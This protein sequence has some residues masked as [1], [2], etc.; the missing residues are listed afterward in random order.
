MAAHTAAVGQHQELVRA[1][2]EASTTVADARRKENEAHEQLTA[3]T[4][5]FTSPLEYLTSTGG[6][7]AAATVASAVG[8]LHG[9]AVMFRDKANAHTQTAS[10]LKEIA[11]NP[12]NT[13][14]KR[15]QARVDALRHTARGNVA[16]T[17]AASNSSK[18]GHLNETRRG[19]QV[20]DKLTRYPGDKALA[21]SNGV[22]AKNA[23][24]VLKKVPYVGGALSAASATTAIAGGADASNTILST[25]TNYA[26]GAAAT[27]GAIALIGSG[28]WAVLG[29]VAV[30]TVA[31]AG[32]GWVVE[33]TGVG[34]FFR[35]VF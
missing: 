21:S 17:R 22:L 20:F 8:S 7:T 24:R 35:D 18:L 32:V 25:A 11:D 28:G 23:N 31:S 12:A 1:Y 5:G 9:A 2:E 16:T 34:D 4:D 13:P 26:V 3:A 29:A 10:A 14:A 19:K 15:A 27:A 6:W 30:G 33:N